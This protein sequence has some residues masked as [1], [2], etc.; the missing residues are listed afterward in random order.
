MLMP[1]GA[2]AQPQR[3]KRCDIG[4]EPDGEAREND[5]END[6]EGKLQTAKQDRIKIHGKLRARRRAQL[7]SRVINRGEMIAFQTAINRSGGLSA[8]CIHN[9][10]NRVVRTGCDRV[11]LGALG[12]GGRRCWWP[13]SPSPR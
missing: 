12:A 2:A 1:I 7:Y 4:R 11:R 9:P 5:V 13:M 8:R 10:L 3:A 6:G